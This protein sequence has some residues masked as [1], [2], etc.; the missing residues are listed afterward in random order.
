[1][2]DSSLDRQVLP[3]PVPVR[4]PERKCSQALDRGKHGQ[5]RECA[6]HPT[7][8]RPNGNQKLRNDHRDHHDRLPFPSMRAKRAVLAMS[9]MDI[10]RHIRAGPQGNAAAFENPGAKIDEEDAVRNQRQ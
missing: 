3:G 5:R 8:R 7:P 2:P 6:N 10:A 9:H 4:P 1:M